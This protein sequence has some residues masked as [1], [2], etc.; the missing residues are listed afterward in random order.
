MQGECPF[1]HQ[2]VNLLER[3]LVHDLSS[4]AQAS[5]SDL[6]PGGYLSLSSYSTPCLKEHNALLI[7]LDPFSIAKCCKTT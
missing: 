1:V 4:V 7:Q 5:R 2:V 6:F 3:P